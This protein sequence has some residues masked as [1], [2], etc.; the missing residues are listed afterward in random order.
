VAV[1]VE[2]LSAAVQ[3]KGWSHTTVQTE[4]ERH[5]RAAGIRVVG[6]AES[7]ATPGVPYLYVN[8][9]ALS[10]TTASGRLV[11]YAAAVRV[12]LIQDVQLARNPS[13]RVDAPTWYA[14]MIVQGPS[15]DVIRDAV[16]A[17]VEKFAQAYVAVNPP[18]A[19]SH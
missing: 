6:A 12:S 16:R 4:A 15:V 14:G 9:N 3:G 1:V 11:G 10:T 8:V 18:E 17:L 7:L 2:A 5:L 19:Q 13:I